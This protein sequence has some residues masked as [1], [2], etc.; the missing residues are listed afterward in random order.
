[1][2]VMYAKPV[3]IR[4]ILKKVYIYLR[5]SKERGPSLFAGSIAIRYVRACAYV[6]FKR[7]THF[8]RRIHFIPY[9]NGY[10][11]RFGTVRHHHDDIAV[12]HNM[13]EYVLCNRVKG[14][15]YRLTVIVVSPGRK[16]GHKLQ[17]VRMA[18]RLHVFVYRYPVA[19]QIFAVENF[20][21]LP[22]AAR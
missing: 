11:C 5:I 10:I 13:Q 4:V 19:H 15:L 9:R 8:T 7:E 17:A 1:M 16:S 6:R 20:R 2:P 14:A 12:L 18:G 3:E 22:D 21:C